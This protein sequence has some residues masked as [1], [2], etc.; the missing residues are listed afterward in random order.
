MKIRYS[1]LLLLVSSQIALAT[2]TEVA[3][4]GRVMRPG[5]HLPL[6][7]GQL[8]SRECAAGEEAR[9]ASAVVY[10]LREGNNT[11]MLNAT[12]RSGSSVRTLPVPAKKPATKIDPKVIPKLPVRPTAPNGKITLPKRSAGCRHRLAP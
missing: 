2:M 11:I 7:G 10:D 12:R 3:G 8:Y 9:V 6:R 1:A 5:N 4:T